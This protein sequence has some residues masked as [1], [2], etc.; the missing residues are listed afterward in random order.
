MY[1]KPGGN[2]RKY[3]ATLRSKGVQEPQMSL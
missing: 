2:A 3:S 1:T